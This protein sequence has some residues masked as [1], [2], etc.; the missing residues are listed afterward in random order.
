MGGLDTRLSAFHQ[1]S[2]SSLC[3][4]SSSSSI[5]STNSSDVDL[6]KRIREIYQDS[7]LDSQTKARKIQRLMTASAS[8]MNKPDPEAWLVDPHEK[9]FHDKGQNVLGC[10][11]YAR[12]AKIQAACCNE[13]FPCRICHDEAK[14]HPIV[15]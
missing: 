1:T 12:K 7:S 13:I 5:S 8:N 11:H 6:R 4:R 9:T 2:S 15:W 10:V 3:R 14:D